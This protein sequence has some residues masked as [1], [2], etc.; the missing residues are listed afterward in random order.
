MLKP[1]D[2]EAVAWFEMARRGSRKFLHDLDKRHFVEHKPIVS[3]ACADYKRNFDMI[4]YISHLR[5]YTPG[6][7]HQTHRLGWHGGITRI[8]ENSPMNPIPRTDEMFLA[9]LLEAKK[10]TKLIDYVV[11]AH[12][13][14]GKALE[15]GLRV[16]DVMAHLMAAKVRLKKVCPELKIKTLFHVDVP[17]EIS[18]TGMKSYFADPED[19]L[20]F[21]AT[22]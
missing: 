2:D 8:V 21:F 5:G 14:C 20:G 11:F 4:R 16:H 9:E 12:W 19:Y 6:E 7:D 1:W 10:I 15:H 3:V 18:S 13:P 22:A 17:Q